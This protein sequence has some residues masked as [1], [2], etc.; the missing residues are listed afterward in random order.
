M[1]LNDAKLAVADNVGYNLQLQDIV[2]DG[3][4]IP[5][6]TSRTRSTATSSPEKNDHR[7][8]QQ[9]PSTG[10]CRFGITI[11]A[12]SISA[13]S[14]RLRRPGSSRSSCLPACLPALLLQLAVPA[15]VLVLGDARFRERRPADHESV[16]NLTA[17]MLSVSCKPFSSV[18]ILSPPPFSSRRNKARD[19]QTDR[20]ADSSDQAGRHPDLVA[21]EVTGR[22]PLLNR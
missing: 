5:A 21:P 6:A 9:D 16:N 14:W 18:I 8:G 17:C 4:C 7:T 3:Y 1:G 22:S 2:W 15:V 12:D 20:Q 13:F 19:V 11:E 10:T